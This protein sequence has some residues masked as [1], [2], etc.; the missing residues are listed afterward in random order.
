MSAHYGK[1]HRLN[2]AIEGGFM[3]MKALARITLLALICALGG[4]TALAQLQSGRILGT[5][6]DPQRAGIPGATVTVTNVSGSK[7]CSRAL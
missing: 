6:L 5:V 7:T 3:M 1:L 2:Q 4:T